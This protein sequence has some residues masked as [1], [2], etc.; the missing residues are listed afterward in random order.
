VINRKV[1]QRPS[2]AAR[3]Y[4]LAV[5]DQAIFLVPEHSSVQRTFNTIRVVLSTTE[6]LRGRQ[7]S[8]QK[9]LL[10]REGEMSR[11]A[12]LVTRTK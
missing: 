8:C 7:Y 5:K 10:V 3:L 1:Y 11:R 2:V 6:A 12:V 9:W 4:H